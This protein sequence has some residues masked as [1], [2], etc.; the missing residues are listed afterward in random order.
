MAKRQPANALRGTVSVTG[1]LL[2][3]SV[4]V[5]AVV[6][7]TVPGTDELARLLA[8]RGIAAPTT[9]L[10]GCGALLALGCLS[11]VVGYRARIGALLLIAFLAL[12][13]YFFHG[14]NLW[15]LLSPQARQEQLFYVATNLSM[16]GAMLFI[17]ANGAGE[18]SVDGSRA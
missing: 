15:T 4:F 14:F 2:L 17:V 13:T 3:C 18:M 11:V 12:T 5:V 10:V 7:S 8:A 9:A 1:R 6:G 16:I